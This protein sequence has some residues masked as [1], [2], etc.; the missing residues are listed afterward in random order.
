MRNSCE[1]LIPLNVC[2]IINKIL[3]IQMFNQ[4][5][6]NYSPILIICYVLVQNKMPFYSIRALISHDDSQCRKRFTRQLHETFARIG[7][8]KGR[9]RHIPGIN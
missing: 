2:K 5:F 6:I 3:I 7:S 1:P 8:V 4:F 9:Y